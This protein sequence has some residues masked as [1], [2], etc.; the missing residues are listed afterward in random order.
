[1][2]TIQ[3]DDEVYAA[4]CSHAVGFNDSENSALRRILK[5]AP[6][7][8]ELKTIAAQRGN[9]SP[10]RVFVESPEFQACKQG[11]D[12]FV[13]LLSWAQRFNPEKFEEAAMLAATRGKRKHFGKS[14]EEVESSGEQVVAKEISRSGIWALTS[15]TDNRTKRVVLGTVFGFMDFSAADLAL[16]RSQI[17]DTD[18]RRSRVPHL[19]PLVASLL[20]K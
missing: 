8:T 14:R 1:M 16:L 17:P 19:D 13:L 4:L 9:R 5:L 18:I 15:P 12:R 3:V 20:D 10:L 7:A 2:H 6:L 11:V